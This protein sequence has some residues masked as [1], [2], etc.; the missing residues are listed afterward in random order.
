M[1]DLLGGWPL[2]CLDIGPPWMIFPHYFDLLS[3]QNRVSHISP[4]KVTKH[5]PGV[6]ENVVLN[7][8]GLRGNNVVG[9]FP[10][11][12]LDFSGYVQGPN[13]GPKGIL[14][15]ATHFAIDRSLFMSA[16]RE[17]VPI[18]GSDGVDSFFIK[19][20][21]PLITMAGSWY[22]YFFNSID[23]VRQGTRAQNALIPVSLIRN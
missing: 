2:E 8:V 17:W 14:S 11:K 3:K 9:H 4:M 1:Q 19:T 6:F 21:I 18:S 13:L 16:C 10:R 12:D 23:L 7:N 20:S 15:G 5:A 22:W